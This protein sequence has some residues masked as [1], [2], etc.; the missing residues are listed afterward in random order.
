MHFKKA[1]SLFTSILV[2]LIFSLGL[3]VFV[4]VLLTKG[5]GVPN[6]FGYSFMNVKTESMVPA[7]PVGTVV[8]T[9]KIEIEKLKAGDVI[10]F[11]SE[12]PIIKGIPNTHRI[13]SAEKNESGKIYFITKGD[14]NSDI[15]KYPV[16]EKD[17]IGKVQGS[18][19]SAGKV[20]AML[21]NRYIFF[22]LFI[23]PLTVIMVFEFRN[24]TKLIKCEDDTKQKS[25]NNN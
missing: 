14:N 12:D 15:D 20:L 3:F 16:Y 19:G 4:T 1:L 5:E 17:L 11:Y 8:I 10:S 21:K 22:F 7:Y 25:Q 9:K 13:F 2:F 24:L 23:I 18:I 6:F